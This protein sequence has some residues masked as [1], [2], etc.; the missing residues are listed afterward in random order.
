MRTRRRTREN[1][2]CQH[3]ILFFDMH[4]SLLMRLH[5]SIGCYDGLRQGIHNSNIH[6]FL[7]NHM[8]RR[9]DKLPLPKFMIWCKHAAIFRRWEECYS[10]FFLFFNTLVAS[11]HAASRAPCSWTLCLLLRPILIFWNIG[12]TLMRF[13][14]ANISARKVF[15]LEF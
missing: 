6:V 15:C 9:H 4:C 10:A 3:D 14:W 1:F 13:T 7:A 12:V 2:Q 11:F 8:H 5:F